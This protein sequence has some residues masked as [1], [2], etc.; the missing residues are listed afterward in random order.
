M[1]KH[2]NELELVKGKRGNGMKIKDRAA[3]ERDVE[4]VAVLYEKI[5]DYLETK[6]NHPR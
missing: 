6:E 1:Q 4:H 3:E 5:H 2:E